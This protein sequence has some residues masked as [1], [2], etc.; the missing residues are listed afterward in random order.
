MG[1]TALL[2]GWHLAD[3]KDE[4]RVLCQPSTMPDAPTSV[5]SFFPVYCLSLYESC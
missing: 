4:V 1:D 2:K 5:I 3:S